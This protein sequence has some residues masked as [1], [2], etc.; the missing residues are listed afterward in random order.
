[1]QLRNG[2]SLTYYTAVI[3]EESFQGKQT[4]NQSKQ[5]FVQ[6]VYCILIID[7]PH[8]R[9]ITLDMLG[10]KPIVDKYG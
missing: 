3:N 9:N 7:I 6:S 10:P 2:R 5:L 8:V 4:P 1:M